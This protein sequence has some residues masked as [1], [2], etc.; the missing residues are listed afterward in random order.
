MTSSIKIIAERCTGCGACADD[1]VANN[2]EIHGGKAEVKNPQ[3]LECGHCFAICPCG[4]VEMPAYDTTD[5][6]KIGDMSDFDEDA[7]LLAMK[8]RRSIRRFK[9]DKVEPGK[10]RKILEAGRYAPTAK[11]AQPISYILIDETIGEMET[12]A[13][14]TFE[15]LRGKAGPISERL[16]AMTL[17]DDFFFRGGAQA[18]LL[19]SDSELDA[20]LAASYMELVAESMGIG[21]LYSG[22]FAVA[23]R[24]GK[25]IREKLELDK[26]E[27]VVCCLVIGYPDVSY[28]RIVPRRPLRVREK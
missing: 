24:F 3:C 26:G 9:P 10:I 13:R 12:L 19:V 14:E 6:D 7:L 27:K 11:N 23:A 20:G 4:A 15:R 2:I 28:A 1:C 22:F 18:V 5:C 8:S 16:S 17:T 25:E 21:V